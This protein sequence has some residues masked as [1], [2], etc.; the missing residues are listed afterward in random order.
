MTGY[1]LRRLMVAVPIILVISFLVFALMEMAPGDFLD[2]ARAQRD[3]S[4]ETIHRLETEYGLDK[5]WAARYGYWLARVA[6]GNFGYSWTYKVNVETLIAQRVPATVGLA[7]ASMALAWIV[8][9]PLGVLAAV[10]K[11]SVFDRVAGLLAYASISLPEFVLALVAY[12]FAATSGLFPVGG[13]TSITS[14]FE[15]FHAR[16]L[17]YLWHLVL[18]T[19]VLGLGGVAGALRI[20]RANF[21]DTLAADFITTARAKGLP[22]NVIRFKHVLRNA[23]NPFVTSLGFAFSGLLSGA[24]VVENI[25]NYPGLGQLTFQAFIRQDEQLVLASVV[26]A[27]VMLIAG[28][29]IADLLLAASDPRIRLEGPGTHG[30][31]SIWVAVGGVL[32]GA[33][34]IAAAMQLPWGETSFWKG[35]KTYGTWALLLAGAFVVWTAYPVLKRILPSL[36]RRP[37][38]CTALVL[39]LLMYAAMLLAPLLAPYSAND[40]NLSSTYHPPAS[41]AWKDGS[42]HLQ[43]M[44][45]ADRTV[46]RYEPI[47]GKT[48]P[49]SFW[50]PTEPYRL[51]GFIPVAHKLFG[52]QAPHKLYLMGSDST[53]RDVFSR[54]LYGSRV[55]LTLGLIGVSI[56]MVLGFMIGG[57]SGYIGGTFDDLVMRGVEIIMSIPGLYLLI[58]LRAAMAQHFESD[59]IF[60]LIVVILSFVGWTGTAR[61]IR[62]MTLSLRQRPFVQ[63]AEAMGQ[64]RVRILLKHILPNL[65]SYLLIS[66]TLSIPGY[67]LGEATLSF[68]GLGIAEPSAS[69]GLM[70]AQAQEMKVLMLGFFWLFVPGLATFLVVMAFNL[71]GDELRDIIDPKFRLGGRA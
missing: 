40:K 7:L 32:A 28:N 66:A 45:N 65:A 55:S 34:L 37:V 41:F 21:L 59:E 24:L 25:F 1:I 27:S 11:D 61:V 10:K 13:L 29:L 19:L 57:L 23:I 51:L 20:M 22:E 12:Y 42:L 4:K 43:V 39:L 38:G 3:I 58:A 18:P 31:R 8:A 46:A 64:S 71:L 52:T 53:G 16:V 5:P 49:V 9:L 48:V 68:L 15:P 6:H 50:V 17:D 60:V 63:A 69:W 14:D 35:L 44:H 47:P 36:I 33:L 62:G 56:T 2:T 70:L 30:R 26:L 54:L 67:I